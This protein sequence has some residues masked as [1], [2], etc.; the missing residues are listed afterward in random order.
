M[1]FLPDAIS[2]IVSSYSTKSKLK[3]R[4][5]LSLTINWVIMIIQQ[6]ALIIIIVIVVEEALKDEVDPLDQ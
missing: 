6:I 1:S 3:L 5:E 2:G 4:I